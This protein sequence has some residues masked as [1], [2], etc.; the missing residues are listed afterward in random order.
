M[1]GS[2]RQVVGYMSLVL[3]LRWHLGEGRVIRRQRVVGALSDH[4]IPGCIGRIGRLRHH[5]LLIASITHVGRFHACWHIVTELRA[6][7]MRTRCTLTSIRCSYGWHWRHPVVTGHEGL[8]FGVEAIAIVASWNGML[9]LRIFRI[10]IGRQLSKRIRDAGCRARARARRA[11]QNRNT[12]TNGRCHSGL[13]RALVKVLRL[14]ALWQTVL[15][16]WLP[17]R[18]YGGGLRVISL[19]R[20]LLRYRLRRVLV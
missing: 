15:W 16:H 10:D 14:P 3:L 8:C 7:M 2:V 17:I 13:V 11:S 9:T 12:K 5:R 4:S 1:D 20:C 19:G 18:C 6:A